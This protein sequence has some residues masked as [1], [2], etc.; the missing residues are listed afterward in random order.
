[1]P[2]SRRRARRCRT[3]CSR[4]SRR[5]LRSAGRGP[6]TPNRARRRR[7]SRCRCATTCADAPAADVRIPACGEP[8]TEARERQHD[9]DHD[10]GRDREAVGEAGRAVPAEQPRREQDREQDQRDEVREAGQ[11]E[12]CD[13][14]PGD[15][16]G[17]HPALRQRPRAQR[18]PACSAR[19]QQRVGRLLG[20]PDPVAE[21]P[22]HPHA[23]HVLEGDDIRRALSRS[24]A[25]GRDHQPRGVCV[26]EPVPEA[27]EAG[28]QPDRDANDHDQRPRAAAAAPGGGSRRA[29]PASSRSVASGSGRSATSGTP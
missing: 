9:R 1:M 28:R 19:R 2:R 4:S 7:A 11:R 5:A 22:R 17:L 12:E 8:V 16:L 3:P 13:R 26:P 6:A 23:E 10:D 14:P 20:H 29:P 15:V 24:S 25:N 27:A 21:P 18:Q